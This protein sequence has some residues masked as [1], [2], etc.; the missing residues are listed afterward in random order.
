LGD[1]CIYRDEEWHSALRS[2]CAGKMWLVN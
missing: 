2:A 1:I